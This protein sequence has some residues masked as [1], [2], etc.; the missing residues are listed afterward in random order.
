MN[1]M[2]TIRVFCVNDHPLL[3]NGIKLSSN[4]F[5]VAEVVKRT[6]GRA[7]RTLHL[8][9]R[10][11][12]FGI[13]LQQPVQLRNQIL[14]RYFGI[15]KQLDRVV[16]QRHVTDGPVHLRPQ[17]QLFSFP[18]LIQSRLRALRQ[19]AFKRCQKQHPVEVLLHGTHAHPAEALNIE[20]VLETIE[21]ALLAPSTPVVLVNL[22]S[23]IFLRIA[24]RRH[25]YLGLSRGKLKPEQPN[26]DALPKPL[27]S[28]KA[29][30][31]ILCRAVERYKA[32]RLVRLAKLINGF[33]ALTTA[34]PDNQISPLLDGKGYQP[35]ADIG[36]I[37]RYY[38]A[39]TR[40]GP[41][42][43]DQHL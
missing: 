28:D 20:D 26:P 22:L 21:V 39:L 6:S 7:G 11:V 8:A 17:L 15:G 18:S 19:S 2:N 23:G 33:E 38:V 27:S 31:L 14:E 24:Q 43:P 42:L 25:Q 30:R 16:K 4:S 12:P 3:R 40:V 36:P 10:R 37:Q 35:I 41:Q 32:L 9:L 34:T 5:P 13:G 29:A 1:N